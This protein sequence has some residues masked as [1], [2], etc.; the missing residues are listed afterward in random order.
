MTGAPATPPG[1]RWRRWRGWPGWALVALVVAG[2][3]VFLALVAGDIAET[4]FKPRLDFS[5]FRGAARLAL[6]GEATAAFDWRELQRAQG[7]APGGSVYYWYYPP[8]F[9]LLIAPLGLLPYMAGF[10]LFTFAGLALFALALGAWSRAHLWVALGSPAV[11][12][13][14]VTG[15]V[16]LWWG[17]ALI[18]AFRL[19]DRPVLAGLMLAA[20]TAKPQLGL[21]L[22]V[23]LIAA[24]AWGPILWGAL[25]T[26][27]L[28]GLTLAVFGADYWV[29][30]FRN[31]AEHGASIAG[32]VTL[33]P[34]MM[35]WYAWLHGLGL[36]HGAALGLQ[37]VATGLAGW[38]VAVAWRGGEPT[39]GMA[40]LCLAIPLSTPY[41]FPYEL[42]L[43]SAAAM[44]IVAGG[45]ARHWPGRAVVL[46]IWS[47]PLWWWLIP[48]LKPAD[49]V[50][51]A[52]G[53]ALG[54]LMLG[55]A[56]PRPG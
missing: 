51:P 27:V 23:A 24:R 46:L 53:L 43:A 1:R 28:A 16:S 30:F 42:A 19:L 9:H 37:L 15:N 2:H 29:L 11:L 49:Y 39:F 35:T 44:F 20:M 54:W 41:A 8:H 47:L 33:V 45:R 55:R 48:G 6:E 52:L 40:V 18:A 21:M 32:Q 12:F 7:V 3:L 25:W 36:S 17:A 22:P 5:V 31:L 38:A 56:A 4:G 10:A 13:A 14:L 26:A 34:E 50:A